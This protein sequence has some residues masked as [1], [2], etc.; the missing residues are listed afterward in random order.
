M[1]INFFH[2]L[3]TRFFIGSAL[4]RRLRPRSSFLIKLFGLNNFALHVHNK[5]ANY[6]YEI[7]AQEELPITCSTLK[8]INFPE[9][10]TRRLCGH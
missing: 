1:F 5:K 6:E 3:F 7:T 4:L 9:H 8:V 10:E 2:N